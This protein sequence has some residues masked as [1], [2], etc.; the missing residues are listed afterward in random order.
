MSSRTPRIRWG[1]Y[2]ELR[3]HLLRHA[4]A[5]AEDRAAV[6]QAALARVLD[7][8]V[9]GTRAVEERILLALLQDDRHD[10]AGCIGVDDRSSRQRVC[11]YARG[12]VGARLEDVVRDA[13]DRMVQVLDDLRLLDA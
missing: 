1:I 7:R 11:C 10:V 4:E 8:G 12:V 3:A 2:A 13:S 9:R 6:E 5:V